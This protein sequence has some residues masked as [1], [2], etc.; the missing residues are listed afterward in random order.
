MK[1]NTSTLCFIALLSV[2]AISVSAHGGR[3]DS[4]GG[5][6]SS[7]G[8]HYHHGYPAHSHYDMDGDG[9]NDCPYD[10]DD[11]TDH[12]NRGNSD[13]ESSKREEITEKKTAGS[14]VGSIFKI[15]GYSILAILFLMCT[16]LLPAID[17]GITELIIWIF[18]KVFKIKISDEAY[19]RI[20]V[21]VLIFFIIIVVGLIA[22]LVL[23]DN[24][25]I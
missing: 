8:Y 1:K 3:T 20:Y 23:K 22:L 2:L 19:N 25:I 18:G 9:K 7:S 17:Y 10:F 24:Q 14:I 16:M 21:I 4:N 5:H 13:N 6:N 12:S 15:L 11:K